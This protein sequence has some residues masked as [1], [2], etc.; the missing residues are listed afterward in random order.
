MYATADRHG[1]KTAAS[2]AAALRYALKL[3]VWR[4]RTRLR[5]I[6]TLLSLEPLPDQDSGAHPAAA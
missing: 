1:L 4:P 3:H 2:E 6:R 5:M